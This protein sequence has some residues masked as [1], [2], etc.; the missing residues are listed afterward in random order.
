MTLNNGAINFQSK[1][2]IFTVC[3]RL[4]LQHNNVKKLR[5]HRYTTW[6][7]LIVSSGAN[8]SLIK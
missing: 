7:S 4:G 8:F 2:I 6:C 5:K 1:L 3:L